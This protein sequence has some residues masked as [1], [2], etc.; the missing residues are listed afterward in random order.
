VASASEINVVSYDKG[1]YQQQP[2]S[3]KKG[4]GEENKDPS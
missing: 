2:R 4:K 3:K 1:K